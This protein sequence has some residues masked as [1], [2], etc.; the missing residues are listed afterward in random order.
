MEGVE[1]IRCEYDPEFSKYLHDI[2][3]KKSQAVSELIEADVYSDLGKKEQQSIIETI[4]EFY[5]LSLSDLTQEYGSNVGFS[6]PNPLSEPDKS[7]L[8]PTIYG[9]RKQARIRQQGYMDKDCAEITPLDL[10]LEFDTVFR[11]S[12]L[13]TIPEHLAESVDEIRNHKPNNNQ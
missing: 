2:L 5:T 10:W 9:I 13:Y 8:T 3:F 12:N 1:S 6:I 4:A 11:K 7:S